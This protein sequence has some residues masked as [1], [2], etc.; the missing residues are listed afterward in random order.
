METVSQVNTSWVRGPVDFPNQ[1]LVLTFPQ[2]TP[3][4]LPTP[5]TGLSFLSSAYL[6]RMRMNMDPTPLFIS[7]SSFPATWRTA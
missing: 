2:K 5:T 4:N 1:R 6:A 7:I 3:T